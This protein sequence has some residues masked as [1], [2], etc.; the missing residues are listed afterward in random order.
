MAAW[1]PLARSGG[2]A[3]YL[4]PYRWQLAFMLAVAIVAVRR[5]DRHPAADQIHDRRGDQPRRSASLLLPIGAAA[6]GLGVLQAL[7]N[8]L[9]RWVQANAVT[10]MEQAMRA[11]IYAHLQRLPPAFH[12]E[13]Q[14]GQ[15]LSRATTDLSAIRR[16]AGF[17]TIFLV[18]NV[19]T[20]IAV[21]VLLIR[22]NWWL[23]LLTATVFLP[24]VAA[25]TRFQ[26]TYRV[27]SR[28]AQDQ[29]GDL[30]TYVEE[31]A[32]GI[33]V[34]KAL[35]RGDEAATQHAARRL[36]VFGTELPEGPAAQHVLGRPGP[37]PERADRRPAAARRHRRRPARADPGRPGRVHHADPG[38]GL[39]H[40]VDGLH[41]GRRP[42]SGHRGAAD[43]RDPGHPARDQQ[44]GPAQGRD[45]GTAVRPRGRGRP[46]SSSTASGSRYPGAEHAL[47]RG[48]SLTVEPGQTMVLAG[49][50]GS[51]KTT[52]LQLVPRLADVTSGAVLLDGTDVRRLPLPMLRSRVG[53]AFEDP[54]LFSASVRENVSY[55]APD[56]DDAA[57]EAA[58]AM[59]QAG[60]VHDLPWGLDTRIGEQGMA[61]SGGQR[62]RVALAR[63]I[64]ARPSLLIL[65]DP[66]SAL[67]VHTEAKVTEALSG[68]LA[69]TTALVVGAPPVHG[70]LADKV[71]LLRDGVIAATGTHAHL[72][73]TQ[74]RYRELMSGSGPDE[75]EPASR[76]R[77]D[78]PPTRWRGIAAEDAEQMTAGLA[79]LLRRRARRLLIQPAAPAA[80]P[81]DRHAAAHR[82]REPGRAGRPVAGR[83][84]HRP[85]HPAAAARRP[86]RRRWSLSVAGFAAAVL[87]QAVTSRAFI[88]EMG[89]LG[90][91]VVLE[92]RQRLFAALPAAAGGLP[93]ALHL[94]P[95]DLPA[96]LRHRL[97]LG[98][99][100]RR[101]GR[102]GVGGALAGPGRESGMLLLDWPLA[103]V[104]L[105]GFGPL[106]GLTIW[107]R[108]E[109][110]VAYR[111]TRE[112]IAQVI[113]HFVETF[114]GIRAVQAFR[115]ES[116]N[117]E[118]FA[119]LERPVRR[120]PASAPRGCWRCTRRGSRWSATWPPGWCCA[121][122]GCG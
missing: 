34:L 32:T 118:I 64:L 83:R 21:V 109:S 72:L 88:F 23:G 45:H 12:D 49:A 56:A 85:R 102:P 41:P 52:L 60:F 18:T 8:F 61:L 36:E 89:R 31:A 121:T 106:A 63:A 70:Q 98:P 75:P 35:G 108:R 42:G 10:G 51:G 94:G 9:R 96:G 103:L 30:A 73:A 66:L 90:E 110:A 116:R 1:T 82:D 7:L 54:T 39:A 14:S 5:R 22:L 43:L 2:P 69:E 59:A 111:R 3:V 99:V 68:L 93:R 77:H 76:R 50:T 114:G 115:R 65:D 84:G 38:A 74:P 71:A 92:L 91:T 26:Q 57:I 25:S 67:D 81:G 95:G 97:D 87:L 37:D 16:F 19:V 113:V 112:T 17:G 80:G 117:E 107:F 53:C 6:V 119:E 62:Q 11:D 20:F 47:L 100:Q 78:R 27:L 86:P 101:P 104:V 46:G 122:A 33:R 120:R 4:R 55:G 24:V 105:A 29:Q 44:P 58:L 79:A 40:R 13:W 28:R 48:V 15:L